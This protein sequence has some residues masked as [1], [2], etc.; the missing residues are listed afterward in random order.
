[1]GAFG[2]LWLFRYKEYPF[3]TTKN[4]IP[5]DLCLKLKILEIHAR[6][7]KSQRSLPG[8]KNC[9]D[10]QARDHIDPKNPG[11]PCVDL[12]MLKM[13]IIEKIDTLARVCAQR[14]INVVICQTLFKTFQ[15]RE[16]T[17]AQ[18]IFFKDKSWSLIL[19]MPQHI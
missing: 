7:Q 14:S 12:K 16:L 3:W 8:P 1:M 11:D 6:T 4:G 15:A 10:P 18:K 9:R 2:A 13:E 19:L 17:R 5:R